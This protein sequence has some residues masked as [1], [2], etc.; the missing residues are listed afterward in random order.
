[1]LPMTTQAQQFEA[2][3]THL[4]TEDGLCSNAIAKIMQDN[5]G[6][7]WIATWNGL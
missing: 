5:Y 4:S 7:I 2:L 3:H 1:M 6:Y